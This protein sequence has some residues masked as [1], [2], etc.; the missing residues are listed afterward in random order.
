MYIEWGERMNRQDNR[1]KGG[2]AG[3]Y[4]HYAAD[5]LYPL[6]AGIRCFVLEDGIVTLDPKEAGLA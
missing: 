4:G 3:F 6:R 5:N 2:N 1:Q